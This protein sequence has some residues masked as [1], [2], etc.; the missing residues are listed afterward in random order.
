[1]ERQGTPDVNEDIFGSATSIEDIIGAL[2]K[3]GCADLTSSIDLT[4]CDYPCT[5]GGFCDV[6]RGT[7]E[8]GTSIAIKSLKVYGSQLERDSEA[9]RLLKRAAR[10]LY[11]WSKLKHPNVLPLMGLA[12]FRKYISMVSGWMENGDLPSYLKQ[13][14]DADRLRL[15]MDVCAGLCYIHKNGMVHGDLKGQNIMISP[16]G[17]AMIADFGNARLKDLTVK[18]GNTTSRGLSYR[19]AAPELLLDDDLPQVSVEADVYA[20][21]MI[22]LETFTGKVPFE[23]INER[24][25]SMLVAYEKRIPPR[26]DLGMSDGLWGLLNSCWTQAPS[27]RPKITG[28]ASRLKTLSLPPSI[29]GIIAVF[30]RHGC[31]DLTTSIDSTTCSD[32]P[33][34]GGGVL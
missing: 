14:P 20:Y 28:V 1:M 13:T 7:L 22:V 29:E 10:E 24:R 12:V 11:H 2:A 3:R 21:G 34:A 31:S 23:G 15:C 4:S 30:A 6:Y 32:R 8:N 17:T 25:V 26:P 16:D 5:G 18:F 27:E 19:W 9:Q 33:N